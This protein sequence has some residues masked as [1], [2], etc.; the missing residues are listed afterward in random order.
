MSGL[1]SL[2]MKTI[3]YSSIYLHV[4]C[5]CFLVCLLWHC[6]YCCCADIRAGSNYII[7]YSQSA[8]FVIVVDFGFEMMPCDLIYVIITTSITI[9]YS[10]FSFHKLYLSRLIKSAVS[11]IFIIFCMQNM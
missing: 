7:N 1:Y 5:T 8:V 9:N 11:H 3:Y 10:I 2:L 4:V 6:V